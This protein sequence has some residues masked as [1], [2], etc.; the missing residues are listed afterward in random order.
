M[1]LCCLLV[2]LVRVWWVGCCGPPPPQKVCQGAGMVQV[3]HGAATPH[4]TGTACAPCE[5]PLWSSPDI[6]GQWLRSFVDVYRFCSEKMGPWCSGD[7]LLC[8]MLYMTDGY[9][10]RCQRPAQLHEATQATFHSQQ[11][12][13]QACSVMQQSTRT[14]K[15]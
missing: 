14:D 1:S 13:L 11:G 2:M 9:Q 15:Y 5:Q 7:Q 6:R 4:T 3:C 8:F 12:T 10:R